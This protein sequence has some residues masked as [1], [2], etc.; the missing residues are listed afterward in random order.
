VDP[1]IVP[2]E[3]DRRVIQ[4][5]VDT[6]RGLRRVRPP[7]EEPFKDAQT[8]EV[9]LAKATSTVPAPSGNVPGVGTCDVYKV[10][11]GQLEVAG[12]SK[13]VVNATISAV[14]PG[15]FC[16]VL[17]DKFGT[18]LVVW[19]SGFQP[20][21]PGA[22]V[23]TITDPEGGV[24]TG[25]YFD[26]TSDD[27][28]VGINADETTVDFSAG[29]PIPGMSKVP[30]VQRCIQLCD[31]SQECWN[32]PVQWLIGP[33]PCP[34]SGSP[35]FSQ[36]YCFG[37]APTG[38]FGSGS[39]SGETWTPAVNCGP[40]EVTLPQYC[41]AYAGWPQDFADDTGCDL[42][43]TAGYQTV[44]RVSPCVWTWQ[45]DDSF[46]AI[47]MTWSDDTLLVE[48]GNSI[49]Q[50][51]FGAYS[52]NIPNMETWD[53]I[54]GSIT[55]QLIDPVAYPN[56][57]P[58]II[59]YPGSCPPPTP[60]CGPCATPPQFVCLAIPG[61]TAQ[62]GSCL[63]CAAIANGV[64]LTYAQYL[65]DPNG[66]LLGCGWSVTFPTGN[67][68]FDVSIADHASFIA[69]YWQQAFNRWVLAI[70][71]RDGAGNFG[72]VYYYATMWDCASPLVLTLDSSTINIA[73]DCMG[74]P[75]TITINPGPCITGSGSGVS[76]SKWYCF[77]DLPA[78]S[79]SGGGSS[80]I[81]DICGPC[82]VGQSPS[83][84]AVTFGSV[85][86]AG[87]TFMSGQTYMLDY[88]PTEWVTDGFTPCYWGAFIGINSIDGVT[89]IAV[90]LF[91]GP[92]GV[93]LFI[94]SDNPM[95]TN[96]VLNTYM[97]TVPGGAW[98]CDGS[99]TFV[100]E[101]TQG[102]FGMSCSPA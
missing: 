85:T 33:A 6:V 10:I 37:D 28:S 93:Q 5:V 53:C 42:F 82:G 19:G 79:G 30:F 80:F 7:F 102:C 77:G 39:G 35:V 15:A 71:I 54:T 92:I 40:C 45:E 23:P 3:S 63:N 49:G 14:P 24:A 18:W 41:I 75:S 90:T 78:G 27:G 22:P 50:A 47:T 96:L 94:G 95:H 34:G 17:R 91:V 26:F 4:E 67:G 72:V 57:P 101:P 46:C 12:F 59:V 52:V 62:V 11:G 20:L 8:P 88:E 97:Q 51:Q 43:S 56:S 84:W 87:I 60:P 68:C 48:F 65:V 55:L 70:G 16:I 98:N 1:L 100:D 74:Y 44:T 21:P 69:L 32:L 25:P 31:G 58:S 86:Q 66:N 99:N 64:T 81:P 9:Y 13:P 29:V 38:P 73:N 61:L 89:P 83:R 36:W 2:T 76:A